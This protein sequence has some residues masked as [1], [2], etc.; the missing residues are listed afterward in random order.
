MICGNCSVTWDDFIHTVTYTVDIGIFF[1]Y[2]G[3]V[4]YQALTIFRTRLQHLDGIRPTIRNL[5]LQNRSFI[6]SDARDKVFRL[7][8]LTDISTSNLY[9]FNQTII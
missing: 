8:S 6:A 9:T 3:D 2:G 4:T 7:L 1:A 5:L